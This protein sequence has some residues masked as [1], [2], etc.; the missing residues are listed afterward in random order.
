MSV[1]STSKEESFRHLDQGLKHDE[2]RKDVFQIA[3]D[4]MLA[5]FMPPGV[6]LN[7]KLDIIQFR[8]DTQ[9][10][11]APPQGKPSF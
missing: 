6:M 1:A 10:W 2:V 7:D 9:A 3:D 5:G 8:G 4:I 11:L